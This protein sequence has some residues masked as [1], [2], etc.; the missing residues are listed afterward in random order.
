MSTVLDQLI[1]WATPEAQKADLLAA[2]EDHRARTG[3]VFDDDRQLEARLSSFLEW[4]V[5][6]RPA[7]WLD[8]AT[9][10]HAR[11]MQA[12]RHE[13]PAEATMFRPYT[14]TVH[15]LFDV[16]SLAKGEVRLV[17]VLLQIEYR[18]S[19]PREHLGFTPGDL[20][21]ARL[22]PE[23]DRWS[24]TPAQTWHPTTVGPLLRAEAAR[25]R[26]QGPQCVPSRLIDDAAQRSLKAD[27]YRQI[28]LERIY[29]F[30]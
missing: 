29:D 21:E 14:E 9:P 16:L 20:I 11:Y 4:Y 12:L 6:D 27:R 30:G 23:V 15:G 5:C 18:V 8:W 26:R 19:D 1:A 22:V 10:A 2:R 28:A 25:R 7:P 24:F 17:D 13:G 3:Q